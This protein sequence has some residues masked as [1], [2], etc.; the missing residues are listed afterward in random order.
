[1][2]RWLIY[3]SLNAAHHSAHVAQAAGPLQTNVVAKVHIRLAQHRQH[4]LLHQDEINI[5]G[6][7]HTVPLVHD[8]FRN[9]LVKAFVGLFCFGIPY[10]YVPKAVGPGR[11]RVTRDGYH[12][13]QDHHQG[14]GPTYLVQTGLL[15]D[16]P[17]FGASLALVVSI[18]C[19]PH[20]RIRYRT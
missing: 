17:I 6:N 5:L 11:E 2:V 13:I 19:S 9:F 15:A 10:L 14:G 18:L 1:M 4:A 20:L 8:P 3:D 12:E 16:S 7:L